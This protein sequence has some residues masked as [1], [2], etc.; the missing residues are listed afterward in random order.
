MNA[1]SPPLVSLAA[2]GPEMTLLLTGVAVMLLA[3]M[4]PAFS[5][6]YAPY[7]S[8]AGI[9]VALYALLRLT[10]TV[11][12]AYDSMLTLDSYGFFFR[13]VFLLVAAAAVLLSISFLTAQKILH[14][15][16]F[17]LL[18]FSVVGMMSIVTSKEL[19]VIFIGIEILSVGLYA[20]AGFQRENVYSVEAAV[21]YF[22]LGAF[23]TSFFLFGIAMVYGATGTTFLPAV[24]DSIARGTMHHPQYIGPGLALLLVGFLFKISAFPFH[25]WTPDVYQGAP[26]P[27]TAFMAVGPKMAGFAALARVLLTAFPSLE[28]EW[29][30]MAVVISAC[31]M[32][33]GNFAALRQNNIKRMLAYSSIAHV[34]YVLMAFVA[35]SPG[36]V[37]AM[38]FYL[39][40][41][42]A[43]NFAAFGAV[44]ALVR[45]DEELVD[46]D[47]Y[48][49][50]GFKNPVIGAVLALSLLSLAGIPPTAGFFGKFF[51][52]KAA[53]QA[54]HTYLVV[55]AVL[56]SALSLYY[57]I[58]PVIFAYM[59]PET[60]E[61]KPAPAFFSLTLVLAA[62]TFF[63]I[64]FGIYPT[65]LY[66]RVT[67]TLDSLYRLAAL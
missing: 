6:R 9:L 24:A 30:H 15:E 40:A 4:A 3:A 20:M 50:L 45:E 27:V 39:V 52:F 42:A 63:I 51:V 8:L 34:G 26:T 10:G 44:I 59:K 36:G 66:E 58:R 47:R 32:L 13:F 67:L 1:I 38:M 35:G 31:T 7:I 28:V 62:G 46:I 43:M 33:I 37:A 21:K 25:M 48:G 65:W 53:L 57:Y 22:L 55:F 18:L 12:T 29:R 54:G 19:L 41:Y 61:I 11:G 64:W 5:R 2:L 49:G 23:S 16:F 17:A 56:N 60:A 14:G